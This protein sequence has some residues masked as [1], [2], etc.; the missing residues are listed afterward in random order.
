MPDSTHVPWEASPR[1]CSGCAASSSLYMTSC[2]H[3]TSPA[4]SWFLAAAMN[5]PRPCVHFCGALQSAGEYS[6]PLCFFSL[7]ATEPSMNPP[8][9]SRGRKPS[10]SQCMEATAGRG[11]LGRHRRQVLPALSGRHLLRPGAA[12]DLAAVRVRHALPGHRG[13]L[14]ARRGHWGRGPPAGCPDPAWL[15]PHR[16]DSCSVSSVRFLLSTCVCRAARALV[17]VRRECRPMIPC[18]MQAPGCSQ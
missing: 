5:V 9:P 11:L 8:E 3:S 12:G 14:P 4:A 13:E 18:R 17:L 15:H 1:A 10:V 7:L 16:C 6:Q 2:L